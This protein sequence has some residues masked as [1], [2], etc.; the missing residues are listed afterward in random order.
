[1]TESV[2]ENVLRLKKEHLDRLRDW[3]LEKFE[4]PE[5]RTLFL[6]LTRRCNENCR[7]CGS[8]CGS[9]PSPEVKADDLKKLLDD[10]KRDFD[11]GRMTLAL[12]GGEPLLYRDFFELARY[13]HSLGFTWGMTTNGTL[14]TPGTA[15]K[16]KEAGI[17]SVS[18]SIDGTK[19]QHDSFRRMSHAYDRA[20]EGV[21]NLIDAGVDPV[22][23]TT[24]VTHETVHDLPVMFEEFSKLDISSWRISNMEPIGRALTCPDLMLTDDEYRYMFDFIREKREAGYPLLYGCQHYLGP[25]YEREV[26]DWYYFCSAG[27]Y[28]ASVTCEGNIV[29]CLDVERRPELVQ[30]SIY[31]DSFAD[32]WKNG[33]G[34]F[35]RDLSKT[36]GKCSS[37]GEA[38]HCMGGPFHSYDYDRKEPLVCFKGVLF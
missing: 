27:V 25:D 34:F 11:I 8:S 6:E 10:V 33:F 4:N 17:G 29:A 2:R 28:V 21:K 36:C 24:V 20:I 37:C 13:A 3:R 31:R 15:R 32:V 7:H 12:T 14:I 26:R 35:R 18:V 23:I 30:G 16:L 22:Q 1:M 9:A 19:A 5:L 38:E